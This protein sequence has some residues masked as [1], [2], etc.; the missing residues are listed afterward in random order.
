[1]VESRCVDHALQGGV[2]VAR[3]ANVLQT[4]DPDEFLH[5]LGELLLVW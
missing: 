4:T 5:K 1:M 2:E 3:V